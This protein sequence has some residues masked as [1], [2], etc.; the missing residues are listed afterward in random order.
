MNTNRQEYFF[1]PR[2]RE[3]FTEWMRYIFQC[4]PCF[5]WLRTNSAFSTHDSELG[6]G[7]WLKEI[8]R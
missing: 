4:S 1:E 7:V 8:Q 6:G 3:K 2:N 5:S